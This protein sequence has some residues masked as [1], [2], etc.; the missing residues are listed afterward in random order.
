MLQFLLHLGLVIP[1]ER[2]I[3]K[4]KVENVGIEPHVICL[5]D[6]GFGF[7]E[8][9]QPHV[10]EAEVLIGKSV[11]WVELYRVKRVGN[12]S[13]VFTSSIVE[14]CQIVARNFIAR[15]NA[16][17]FFVCLKSFV[18]I[19]DSEVVIMREDVKPFSLGYSVFQIE[20]FPQQRF[21]LRRFSEIRIT[22]RHRGVCHG[23]V[24]IEFDGSLEVRD[25]RHVVEMLMLGLSQAECLKSLQGGG[26]RLL[27]GRCILLDGGER[28]T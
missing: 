21:R 3:H 11:F 9:I 22:S 8:S 25:C 5:P 24:R 18:Y 13:L 26:G 15:I 7:I 23:E 10:G 19:I 12:G 2:Q 4:R 27:K 28:F 16:Q 17:P 14:K 6:S 1:N 20:R